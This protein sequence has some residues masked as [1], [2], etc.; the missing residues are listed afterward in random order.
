MEEIGLVSRIC[1]CT[2][3]EFAVSRWRNAGPSVEEA[4]NQMLRRK[5]TGFERLQTRGTSN[6]T[7]HTKYSDCN[8]KAHEICSDFGIG[9]IEKI[10]QNKRMK[11][12]SPY[13]NWEVLWIKF[14]KLGPF[15]SIN[16]HQSPNNRCSLPSRLHVSAENSLMLFNSVWQWIQKL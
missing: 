12:P 5:M 8:N 6:L 15:C 4:S 11:S 10:L 16:V 3:V 13:L 9:G 7:I 2:P 1:I 14:S